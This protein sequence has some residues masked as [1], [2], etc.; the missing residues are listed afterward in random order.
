MEL[1]REKIDGLRVRQLR[2]RDMLRDDLT[3]A[4]FEKYVEQVVLTTTLEKAIGWAQ[5]NSIYPMTFGLACCSIEMMSMMASP[6]V[7]L[8][9]FGWEAMRAS[10]RQ[11]DLII[12]AGRISTKMAPIVRRVY[13]Q[14]LEPKFAISMGA[15]CSSLGIFSNYALIPA[16]KFMPV[17][18]YVPGCPPR[19]EALVHGILKLR[20]KIQHNAKPG[21]RERYKAIGT[22]EVVA[23]SDAAEP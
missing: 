2:A 19:P 15:C 18:V 6:R 14:M 5:G 1:K 12:L 4:E 8:D 16:D 3:D 20:E 9:R 17:D 22:E 23:D 10:P 7:D 11:A 13:D 21:S